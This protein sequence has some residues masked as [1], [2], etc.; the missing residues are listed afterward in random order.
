LIF[1]ESLIDDEHY[2]NTILLNTRNIT[3][4]RREESKPLSKEE[5][6]AE[7]AICDISKVE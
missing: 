2:G 6:A 4:L 7:F 1:E 3:D 5:I